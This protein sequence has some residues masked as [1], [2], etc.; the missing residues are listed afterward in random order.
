MY[1]ARA[2]KRNPALIAT[3]TRFHQAGDIPANCFVFDADAFEANGAALRHEAARHGLQLYFM[4]KQHG[5]NPELFRRVITPGARETVAVN[6]EDAR[7]LHRYGIGLGHIGNL[8]QAPRHEL[9]KVIATY[10][11]EVISVFSVE[12]A[13]Q[14]SAVADAYERKQD[15][16][17]RVHS[18]DDTLFPGMEGGFYLDELEETAHTISQLPGIRIVGV[19]TFPALSYHH[20][21]AEPVATPNLDALIAAKKTLEGLGIEVTQVNA[22]GNNSC[23]T[24][25]FL[26]ER[27]VTHVEPG[28]ALTGSSTFHLYHDDLP[29]DPA[30]VY[31]TEIS[32]IWD[33]QAY[34]YGGGFFID[35]PPVQMR[36][37]FQRKALV[38][39]TPQQLLEQEA[40]FLGIG[41]RGGGQFAAIDYHGILDPGDL[42]VS[43]GDTAI[44][45]FRAQLFMTRA[46]AAVIEGLRH[47]APRLVGVW[48]WSGHRVGGDL[49]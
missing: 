35:D 36:E 42:R 25:E 27:G 6:M 37:T 5:R 32:H 11:P 19:T 39:S 7:I 1:L 18:R 22:P 4:T 2:R 38:G 13:K 29:E 24:M 34:V 47:D 45:A 15:V 21:G 46:Y 41:A 16:L 44:F 40:A 9:P 31:L 20:E 30:M 26:A 17:L 43:V 28:S 49:E 23:S 10:R 12:K 14:V 8:V 48:D 3:A 33:R